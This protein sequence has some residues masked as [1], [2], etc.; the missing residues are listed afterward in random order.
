MARRDQ[1]Y[2]PL[3]VQDFMTDEKLN[4]CSAES[5]GVY[6]RLMCLMHKSQDYG[7][8]LLKQKDKQK[9]QQSVKQGE[10]SISDFAYKL[11]KH[12]PYDAETIERS[13]REL[14]DEEVIYI[15]GDKLCQ[16]RMIKDGKISDSRSSAGSKGGKTAQTKRDSAESFANDFA[17]AKTQANS[18]N[19]IEI[20]NENE[21][22]N[23]INK[24]NTVNH[25][26]VT[27]ERFDIFWNE[28][29]RKVGKGQAKKIWSKIAPDKALFE[30]IMSALRVVKNCQQWQTDRGQFIPHPATWLNQERWDDEYGTADAEAPN[31]KASP[32]YGT[33]NLFKNFGE[34]NYTPE[35]LEAFAMNTMNTQTRT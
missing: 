24:N 35:E 34:R 3:Y 22:E 2:L 28:Y 9:G 18:E 1:P 27:E 29:P 21:N 6:I 10:S 5:T 14:I 25:K 26:K 32:K 12:M 4:E 7:A 15:D 17:K 33:K 8:I 23:E 13:L 20:E 31:N 11:I 16:K 30:K 19:E